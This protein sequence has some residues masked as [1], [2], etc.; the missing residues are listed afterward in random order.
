MRR[1]VA[2][3]NGNGN[4]GSAGVGGG[5]GVGSAAVGGRPSPAGS[6]SRASGA[7]HLPKAWLPYSSCI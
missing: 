2:N 6:I 5:I 4:G 3:G 7:L 1:L